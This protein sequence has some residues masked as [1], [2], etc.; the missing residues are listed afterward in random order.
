MVQPHID[1]KTKK[2]VFLI[3]IGA[4]INYLKFKKI[5]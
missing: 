2:Y 5:E 4:V 3:A 1:V